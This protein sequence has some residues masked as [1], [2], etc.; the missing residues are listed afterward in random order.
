MKISEIRE[1]TTAELAERIDTEVANYSNMK[2]NHHISP[3]EDYSQ[4]KK[5]R[6]DIA[7]MKCELRQR[8]LNK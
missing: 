8:E 5:L 4:I 3:L 6:R 2:F 7:R 1:L